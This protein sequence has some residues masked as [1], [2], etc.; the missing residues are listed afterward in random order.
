[1]KKIQFVIF[2]IM[3]FLMSCTIEEV[4]EVKTVSATEIEAIL[5]PNGLAYDGC[6]THIQIKDGSDF[7]MLKASEKTK[8]LVEKLISDE[9]AKMPK[10]E[11]IYDLPVM[12]SYNKTNQKVELL[13]GWN[14][15]RTV[16]EIEVLKI[17][18]R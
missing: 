11:L 10:G 16:E 8:G 7:V 13:C 18:K 4:V 12:I 1:M 3:V 15:K 14:I 2:G 17:T 5:K 9:L 6:D